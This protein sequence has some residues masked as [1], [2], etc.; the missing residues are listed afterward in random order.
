M[1]SAGAQRGR[2]A[3]RCGARSRLLVPAPTS[4]L[5]S[6]APC[7]HSLPAF[8]ARAL[9]P[10]CPDQALTT[11]V[12]R[13]RLRRQGARSRRARRGRTSSRAEE[14]GLPLQWAQAHT[15]WT[16]FP[17][18][19]SSPCQ[20]AWRFRLLCYQGPALITRQASS[21]ARPRRRGTAAS[22]AAGRPRRGPSRNSAQAP[23]RTRWG[24]PPRLSSARAAPGPSSPAARSGLPTSPGPAPTSRRRPSAPEP[25]ARPIGA[26]RRVSGQ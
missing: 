10:R 8:A 13:H 14:S 21:C 15:M 26:N 19:R 17:T 16:T 4:C 12:S 24:R 3:R 9:N 20:H 7:P 2:I 11:R 23:A 6:S 1:S 18:G 5:R 22:R 25:S